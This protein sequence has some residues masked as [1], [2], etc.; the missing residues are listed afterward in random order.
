M[1]RFAEREAEPPQ[2]EGGEKAF[3]AEAREAAT[4][5]EPGEQAQDRE[6]K[7]QAEEEVPEP[8]DAEDDI[9]E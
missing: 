6:E 3:P 7:A 2:P 8:D 5:Q 9:F 1:K 4:G